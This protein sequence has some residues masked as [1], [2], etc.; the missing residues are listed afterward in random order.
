MFKCVILKYLFSVYYNTTFF[1]E[2]LFTSQTI[3]SL[4]IT[5]VSCLALDPSYTRVDLCEIKLDARLGYILSID[6]KLLQPVRNC[7]VQLVIKS[8]SSKNTP[9]IMNKTWDA[10]AFM[11][12]RKKFIALNR[13]F[14]FFADYTNLNHS[15][16]FYVSTHTHTI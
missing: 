2:P 12:S 10:C 3:C 1:V 6:L 4:I 7:D 13:I 9:P 11:K 16:P 14:S 8:L 5:N 15:C